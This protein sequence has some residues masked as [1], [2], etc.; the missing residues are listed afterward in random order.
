MC[1][2]DSFKLLE[3][4][5][6][7]I[8]TLVVVFCILIRGNLPPWHAAFSK[9]K[10]SSPALGF[11]FPNGPSR[12]RPAVLSRLQAGV[13]VSTDS[14][15]NSETDPWTLLD[16]GVSSGVTGKAAPFLK[17]SVRVPHSELLAE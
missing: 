13:N 9:L 17:G 6:D 14:V 11:T 12:L 2:R 4:S 16:G 15:D 8:D 3:A 5:R 7:S 10:L 1:I